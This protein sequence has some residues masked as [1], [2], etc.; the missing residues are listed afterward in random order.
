MYDGSNMLDVNLIRAEPEK[1]KQGIAAKNV[2]PHVVDDFLVADDEWRAL[3]LRVDAL[4]SEQK[5]AG[6][7]GRR[8]EA[9]RIKTELKKR[10]VELREVE[11]QRLSFLYAIPNLPAKGVPVGK[12]EADNVVLR[13][14]GEKPTFGFPARNYVDLVARE[15]LIDTERAAKVSGSRFGYLRGEAARLE[16]ALVQFALSELGNEKL[17]KKIIKKLGLH[18]PAKP[19]VPVIPPVLVNERAM[20]GMGYLERGGDEVYRIEKDNLYLVGTSEQALG[21]MHSDEIID[22]SSLPL[23]YAGY[24]PCF[25]REAGSYG[26]DTKGILRV[27]QF[28]KVELFSFA[29]PE[30]SDAEHSL[31]FGLAEHMMSELKLPYRVV[32]IC[33]ADLGDPAAAKFDIEAWMPGQNEGKGEYRETHSAS[34]TTDFQARRLNV[35]YRTPEGP[36]YVHMLNGT[37]FAIGRILIAIIENYQKSDGSIEV[38]KVLQAYVGKKSIG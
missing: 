7:A 36:K 6:A 8:E 4:R 18:L 16:I 5:K 29:H 10:E 14:E 15:G 23:R 3:V 32:N 31:I 34:T 24:S 20:R 21:P 19:F 13:E 30:H 35:R 27:H 22:A 26:K 33:T 9:V 2:D 38:P 12:S 37:M 25:R 1:V 11:T 28:D 17:V